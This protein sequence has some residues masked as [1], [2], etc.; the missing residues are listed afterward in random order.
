M[1]RYKE[2]SYICNQIHY[3]IKYVY[4]ELILIYATKNG[5][6]WWNVSFLVKKVTICLFIPMKKI[7]FAAE[8]KI[9]IKNEKSEST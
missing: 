5:E 3:K 4:E 2:I 1:Q 6:K 9:E 8:S 7:N